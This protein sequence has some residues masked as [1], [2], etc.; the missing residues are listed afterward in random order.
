MW[1][2]EGWLRATGHQFD[3]TAQNDDLF[4]SDSDY[5]EEEVM[6]SSHTL[7]GGNLQDCS[8]TQLNSND[9][10]SIAEGGES[11]E[12]EGVEGQTEVEMEVDQNV[13]DEDLFGDDSDDEAQSVQEMDM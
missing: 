11:Y 9:G 7:H 3:D 8:E 4:G 12:I 6:E 1:R 2:Q 10:A 5:G 13:D